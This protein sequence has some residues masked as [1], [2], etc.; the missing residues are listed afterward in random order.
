MSKW[1]ETYKIHPAA[2]VFPMMSDDQLTKLGQD[3][4]ANGLGSP[5]TFFD[6]PGGERMLL[7]GRNRLE[8]MERVGIDY[9]EGNAETVYTDDPVAFVITRNIHRRHLTKQERADLIVAAHK[10]AAGLR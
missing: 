7:D 5:I 1:R 9:H 8:A 6:P 3:I 10:A 2:D 4:K